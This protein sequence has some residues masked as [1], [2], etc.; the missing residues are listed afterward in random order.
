[1]QA[2][3]T[4]FRD[5]Q[6]RSRLEATWACFFELCG[7]PWEYEPF[8]MPGWIPDF[9]LAGHVLVEVKP[10]P[11]NDLEVW[12]SVITKSTGAWSQCWKDHHV[13]SLLLLGTSPWFG[14]S[15]SDVSLGWLSES[16]FYDSTN[17][18]EAWKS[19]TCQPDMDLWFEESPVGKFQ[20]GK[21]DFCHCVGWFGG[22]I[23]GEYDG[24]TY[25]NEKPV[26]KIWHRAKNLTQWKPR[27]A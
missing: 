17:V 26:E 16:I 4:M 11:P 15:N 22:R 9:V 1:M 6:M 3:P 2:I 27:I 14:G 7:W 24:G 5:V 10:Y 23:F 21:I 8:D 20:S 12:K 19:D 25:P 13:D 18:A